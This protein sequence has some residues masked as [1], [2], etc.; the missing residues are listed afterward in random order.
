M[1]QA[2]RTFSATGISTGV[3]VTGA[4]STTGIPAAGQVYTV[5]WIAFTARATS[6]SSIDLTAV[7]RAS[8]GTDKT[9][10]LI[11]ETGNSLAAMTKVLQFPD[12]MVMAPTAG[13]SF[14]GTVTGGSGTYDIAVGYRVDELGTDILPIGAKITGTPGNMTLLT[15]TV[16]GTGGTIR[17]TVGGVNALGQPYNR[18]VNPETYYGPLL[19]G[20]VDSIT[21]TITPNAGMVIDDVLLNGL[22][23]GAL[24]TVI[25]ATVNVA[26]GDAQ[27]ISAKFKKAA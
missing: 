4:A 2:S 6:V 15:T 8:D 1:A 12:G 20:P 27:T 16:I 5:S 26:G 25:V 7:V 11:H 18:D 19:Y 10:T 14:T 3:A 13:L 17:P 21:F 24:G 22:S 9:V 23:L